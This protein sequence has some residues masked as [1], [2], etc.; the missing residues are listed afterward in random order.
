[1]EVQ[2]I[3]KTVQKFNGESFYL[4][5]YYFQHKGKRL[6]RAVWEYHNG[7]IPKGY[8]VHHKDENRCNNDISNLTLMQ[9]SA[10]LSDHMSKEERKE[11]S[12]EDIKK[13]IEAAPAWHHSE[14]GKE[15]H[16]QHSKEAWKN[17][18]IQTYTCSFCGKEFQTK[19]IYGVNSNHFCHPNCKAAFR[20]RRIRN[21]G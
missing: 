15:W 9:G 21:E 20:R 4:C 14:E 16:S 8:H 1:M 7:A 5:G 10:H 6:H 19:H 13:A 17:R 12:R 3:S 2:V 18:N 11:K